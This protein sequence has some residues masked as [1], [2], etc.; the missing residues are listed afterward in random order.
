MVASFTA[1]VQTI[2]DRTLGGE[3][4]NVTHTRAKAVPTITEY[5]EWVIGQERESTHCTI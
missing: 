1:K 2:K 5:D 3:C 4:D